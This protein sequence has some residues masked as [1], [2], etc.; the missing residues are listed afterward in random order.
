MKKISLFTKFSLQLIIAAFIVVVITHAVLL[1]HLNNLRERLPLW[2]GFFRLTKFTASQ[3]DLSDLVA[4]RKVL[5]EHG[6]EMRYKAD[7]FEWS[8]SEDVPTIEAI[9]K[10][11]HSKPAFWYNKRLVSV[12]ETG[13]GTYIFQAVNPFKQLSVPWEILIVWSVLLVII[14]GLAHLSTRKLLGPVR[15]LHNGVKQ[16]SVG[17]FD[18]QLP[19]TSNDELGELIN[20]FNKMARRIHNDIKIRDQ[21]LRDISHELRSPL[22]RI[23]LALE[24]LPEGNIRHTI[25]NNVITLEKMTS[26][27]LEEARLDSPYGGVKLENIDLVKLISDIAESKKQADIPIVINRKE[28]ITIAA[29]K[30]RIKMAFSNVIDNAI[31]YS[32][33]DSGPVI[34]NY[35]KEDKNAV[36]TVTDKGI[37]ISEKEIAFVFEP[38]YRVDKARSHNSGGYGLGMSLTK[39]IIEAHGGNISIQSCPDEGTMVKIMLPV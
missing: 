23:L 11:A 32:R 39:K 22:A 31:K 29:D 33:P 8:S 19:Q 36:I 5:N 1:I 7:D 10:H 25:K 9:N 6:L 30:E 35:Y 12:F 26:T 13:R 38:F 15:I 17:R 34:L 27:I 28:P 20:S 21:L 14:F 4:T 24:F 16:I 3:I 2:D 18:I 37:G